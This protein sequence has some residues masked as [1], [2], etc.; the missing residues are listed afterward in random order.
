MIKNLLKEIKIKL[1]IIKRW[2]KNIKAMEVMRVV[3]NVFMMIFI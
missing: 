3:V 1:I 2:K